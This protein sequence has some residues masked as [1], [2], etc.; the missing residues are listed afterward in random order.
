MLQQQNRIVHSMTMPLSQTHE[1]KMEVVF[2]TPSQNCIGSGVC[3][4]MNRAP[5]NKQLSCPHAPAWLS[6]QQGR[7][8]FRFLKEA[9]TRQDCIARFE[10]P[11][12]LVEE[13][14]EIPRTTARR[15]GMTTSWVAPGLYAVVETA[16]EWFLAFPLS[17]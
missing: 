11:W 14:F 6:Y 12:F 1:V 5:Q 10:S 4:L 15:L 2:G 9:V 16:K 13:P 3:M 8:T 17:R 7:L